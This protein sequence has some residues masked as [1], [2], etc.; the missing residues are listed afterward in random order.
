LSIKRQPRL[1]DQA[2]LAI[3]LFIL[4]GGGV[5]AGSLGLP[6]W[7]FQ[8]GRFDHYPLASPRH[9]LPL[10]VDADTGFGSSAFNVAP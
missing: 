9:D 5:A 8:P 6:T 2:L 7:A 10:L 3:K 4:S 1:T